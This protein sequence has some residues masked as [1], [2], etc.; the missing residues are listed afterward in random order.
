MPDRVLFLFRAADEVRAYLEEEL[1]DLPLELD[2][3]T[4]V[5]REALRERAPGAKVLV[6]W[7]YD[8]ELLEAARDCRVC[9]NPGAGVQHLI[10]LFRD[11]LSA[12]E[13]PAT[14]APPI[15]VNSH[16]NAALTAQG[17]VALLLSLSNR[18]AY[19][20]ASL[21]RGEWNRSFRREEE[22]VPSVRLTD[23]RLGLLG[24]GH[25]NREVRRLLAPFAMECHIFRRRPEN[26]PASVVHSELNSFLDAVDILVAAVPLTSAT[27]GMLGATELDRLGPNGLLVHVGRG[28]VLDQDALFVALRDRRIAGAAID[29]WYDYSP[30]P[31]S[32]GR[33]F[34]YQR[35][36]HELDSV[37]LS[38]HRAASPF[39]D[40]PRWKDVSENLRRFAKGRPLRHQVDLT[41]E[42]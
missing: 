25:V 38:P 2:F 12:V 22:P 30:E 28:E 15:L 17:A 35:P 20:D 34:P 1:A 31:D 36:F 33:R 5:S 23:R 27:K 42:Y 32:E 7:R 29:V 10:P 9:I 24:Y 26:E 19:H 39:A 37:V 14:S 41:A 11:R 18:T 8:K 16:G 40:I 6:G 13:P 3:P 21:R 4:E